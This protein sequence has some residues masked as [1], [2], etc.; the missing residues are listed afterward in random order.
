MLKKFFSVLF[1]IV[2][3]SGFANANSCPKWFPMPALEGLVVV[4]HIYDESITGPDMDCDEILDDVDA[5]IDGDGVINSRDPF[6]RNG[7][8]WLD[9]DGDGIGNNADNDDDNDGEFDVDERRVGSDP[10]DAES[11]LED[12]HFVITVKTDNFGISDNNEFTIPTISGETYNYN[13]NVD[14]NNDGIDEASAITGDYTCS[15]DE[16]GVYTIVIKDNTGIRE[17]F[18]RIAFSLAND[19]QKLLGIN[20]WGTGKWTSMSAAFAW[21]SNLNDEGGAALDVPDL[22]RVTSM[23]SMFHFALKF[24]Q[25]I[26]RWDTSHVEAMNYAFYFSQDFNQDLSEWDTHNVKTMWG[27]FNGA[28]DFNQDIGAWDTKSVTNMRYMFHAAKSFDQYIGG[29]DVSAVTSMSHMF[30]GANTFDQDLQLWDTARVR[31][32]SYMF[33][34]ALAFDQDIGNWDV[35]SVTNMVYM[36]F[37]AEVFDKDIGDWNTS[38]VSNMMFMFVEAERFNQDIGRWDVRKVKNMKSMF[39]SARSFNQDLKDWNTSVVENMDGMFFRTEALHEQNLSSWDVDNID[40]HKEFMKNSGEDNIEPIWPHFVITV[41]TDNVGE[42]EDNQFIIPTYSGE[43]YNYNVDCDSD[44]ID[45]N[46]SVEGNCTCTYDE[47][48]IYTITIKDNASDHSG[49][50]RIYFAHE[51]DREKIV[52]INQWGTMHWKSMRFAF[53]GCSELN[54]T[55]GVAKD[56]PDLSRVTNISLM[57][58]GARYFNQD[59]SNWDTSKI[60]RMNNVF[61]G[62]DAFNQSIG[63]WDVRAVKT[64]SY[65][66]TFTDNF[67]QDLSQWETDSLTSMR[68]MFRGAKAFNQNIETFNVSQVTDMYRTFFNASAFNQPLT[69]WNTQVGNVETMKEMFKQAEVFEQN[70]SAWEVKDDVEHSGFAE[71]SLMIEEPHW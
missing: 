69:L 41:K 7:S 30:D 48:G 31:D 65:M 40:T 59:I 24:N 62:A 61:S 19:S 26:S 33:K 54:A 64:M 29:W 60:Q 13:Y 50:P 21:C 58:S 23:S 14:C 46:S 4:I 36:F 22:S 53:W 6:P 70:L 68:S 67:N 25:D 12:T 51:G 37:D 5:D 3:V 55:G 49:F 57:F 16:E 43:T 47:A 52:G 63:K 56:T 66:F 45:E 32:M 15:Y 39:S 28:S 8:E 38:N 44:G 17:G 20:Q 2:I 27:M 42:S 9:T 18:P 35:D 71:D 11:T 34:D 1:Q 10:L